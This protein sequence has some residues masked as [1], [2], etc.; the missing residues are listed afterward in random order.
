[1]SEKWEDWRGLE[2]E[3]VKNEWKLMKIRMKL[4]HEQCIYICGAKM[5]GRV[6]NRTDW[7]S[8]EVERIC[9]DKQ[10]KFEH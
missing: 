3:D 2:I 9:K 8:D 4:W 10:I 7:W 1:M 5:V 6:R